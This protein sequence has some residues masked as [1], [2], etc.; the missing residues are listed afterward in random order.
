MNS[1]GDAFG[2]PF[3][4]GSWLGKIVLQGLITIIPIV[5]WI[6]LAGWMLQTLDNV[7]AGRWELAPAGFYLGRGIKLFGVYLIYGIVLAI[8]ALVLY[9]PGAIL[10]SQGSGVGGLLIG[11]GSLYRALAALFLLFLYPAIIVATWRGGFSG[12]MDVAAVWQLATANVTNSV[13]AGLVI[14]VAGIIGGIG[15]VLC[16]IGLFF[17]LAYAYAIMAGAAAWFDQQSGGSPA[18]APTAPT[19]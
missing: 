11:L 5:G 19:F 2:Y 13:L 8:P 4:D 7:R 6:A 18:P 16:F 17:T 1:L 15:F 10:L 3:R 14:L 12:G 9:I